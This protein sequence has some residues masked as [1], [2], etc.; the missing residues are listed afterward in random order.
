VAGL[1]IEANDKI[2]YNIATSWN[3]S[4]GAI[5]QFFFD[6]T[7]ANQ[8]TLAGMPSSYTY[9]MS[10]FTTYSDLDI[11]YWDVAVTRDV[12]IRPD[13]SWRISVGYRKYSDKSPYLEDETGHVFFTSIATI[14]RF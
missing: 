13:A 6:T 3:S 14:R 7:Q 9:D 5:G 10:T 11:R 1:N 2:R 12:T 4:D 8:T